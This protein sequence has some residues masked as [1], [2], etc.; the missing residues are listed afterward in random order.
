[1]QLN[2]D[3]GKDLGERWFGMENTSAEAHSLMRLEGELNS[4]L[5]FEHGGSQRAS[6]LW[7]VCILLEHLFREWLDLGWVVELFMKHHR[8]EAM[9]SM[10]KL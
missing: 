8:R 10:V 6:P 1:V 7:V 2:G 4:S 3:R 5:L 9:R